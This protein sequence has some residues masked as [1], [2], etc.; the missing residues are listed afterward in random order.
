VLLRDNART[1]LTR[2]R[3]GADLHD[4][5]TQRTRAAAMR[6]A[7]RSHEG[8]PKQTKLVVSRNRHKGQGM[9][10]SRRYFTSLYILLC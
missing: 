10:G 8:A 5:R 1:R 3:P 2:T 9:I 7:H 6:L 4:T